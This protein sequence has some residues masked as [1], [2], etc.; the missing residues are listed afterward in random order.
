MIIHV[1]TADRLQ[2][3]PL[4]SKGFAT[5]YKDDAE[6][7][8]LF[9]GTKSTDFSL[10]SKIMTN[11]G[12]S[13]Y[14]FCKSRFEFLRFVVK[15][16]NHPFL[17]HAGSY[18]WFIIAFLCGCKNVNWVCWGSGSQI[19]KRNLSALSSPVKRAIYYKFSSIITLMDDDRWSLVRDFGISE[20]KVRTISYMSLGDAINNYDLLSKELLLSGSCKAISAKPSVLLGNNPSC[21]KS[22]FTLLKQLERFKG[23]ISIHCMLNYSL[24]KNKE[25]YDLCRLGSS[26]F[27]S[28]F[29]CDEVFYPERSDYIRYMNSYDIYICGSE[30]Q[31]G[32]GAI[33]TCL[34]LGKKIFL[35]GKNFNWIKNEFNAVI[36][37]VDSLNDISYSDFVAPLSREEMLYNYNSSISR[38]AKYTA[39]WREYLSELDHKKYEG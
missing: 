8:F 19:N 2:L 31:S 10:Y 38:K 18:S 24:N 22:Y 7:F 32:I 3:V 28:D 33:E 26:L 20:S 25:Y 9:Y 21:I 39:K 34:K 11:I 27:S 16:R 6:S 4:I 1:F 30:R 29:V 5:I 15:N 35:T 14:V 23:Q 12:F 36:F 17:F 37:E 13:N